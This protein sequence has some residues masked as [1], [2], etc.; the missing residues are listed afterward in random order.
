MNISF[1]Q[2]ATD[3]ISQ[4]GYGG[5]FLGLFIDSFGV[6]IPSE[7]LIPLG[8]VLALDGRFAVWAVFAIGTGAQVLG[9]LVGYMIGRY[10]G[11]PFLERYGKY[12]L[13]TKRDLQKTRDAFNKYGIWMTMVGRCLP[14]IRGLIGYPAGI[15]EMPLGTF[16]LFT[17]IGSA[18]WT[19]LLMVLGVLLRNN[20]HVIDEMGHKFSYLVLVLIV[21]FVAWH[22]RH[23]W[24]EKLPRNRGQK[25]NQ[26]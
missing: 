16:L 26:E 11:E 12:I 19:V 20:L 2:I 24:W 4:L 9:G 6:P 17:A 22:F 13:I 1:T 14:V 25:Q 23:Y 18:A 3:L 5:L 7:V 15:A 21:A 10:G 8:M